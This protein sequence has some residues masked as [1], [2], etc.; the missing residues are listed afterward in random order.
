MAT[1]EIT[2]AWLQQQPTHIFQ[3]LKKGRTGEL[4]GL[5]RSGPPLEHTHTQIHTDVSAC[6]KSATWACVHLQQGFPLT[7]AHVERWYVWMLNRNT[8]DSKL[9][10]RRGGVLFLLSLVITRPFGPPVKPRCVTCS[11][12]SGSD[13]HLLWINSK[14]NPNVRWLR[15]NN[16]YLL[17]EEQQY[18]R[19]FI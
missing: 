7:A 10:L 9:G 3:T 16:I 1:A 11:E 13:Q 17:T 8:K 2:L 18:I 14:W 12:Q 5:E 15:A 4:C 6:Q 19:V